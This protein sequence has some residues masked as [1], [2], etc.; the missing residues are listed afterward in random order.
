MAAGI[1]LVELAGGLIC[2]YK[3]KEFDLKEGRILASNPIIQK[4]L[5]SELNKVKPLESKSLICQFE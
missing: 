1:P 3:N 5:L 4:E 2:D